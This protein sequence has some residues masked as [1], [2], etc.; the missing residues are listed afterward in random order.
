M[1]A[2]TRRVLAVVVEKVTRSSGAAI[3]AGSNAERRLREHPHFS[4]LKLMARSAIVSML[5]ES[6]PDAS[7]VTDRCSLAPV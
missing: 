5:G 6:V 2:V 3:S 4:M 7:G 1:L